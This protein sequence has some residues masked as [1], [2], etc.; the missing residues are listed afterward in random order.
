MDLTASVA[1]L[2]NY[3]AI[4]AFSALTLWVERQEGQPTCKKTQW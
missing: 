1:F 3:T 2:V 4:S